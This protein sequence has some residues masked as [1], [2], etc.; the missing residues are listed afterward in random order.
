MVEM[1]SMPNLLKADKHNLSGCW[2]KFGAWL[3]SMV[4]V[5]VV[6]FQQHDDQLQIGFL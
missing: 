5:F 2:P 1:G 3:S 6:L 4:R